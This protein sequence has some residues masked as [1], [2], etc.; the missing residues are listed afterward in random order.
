MISCKNVKGTGN[1]PRKSRFSPK[2]ALKNGGYTPVL[3]VDERNQGFSHKI[4]T[5]YPTGVKLRNTKE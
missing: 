4:L 2:L 3:C 1:H 5:A